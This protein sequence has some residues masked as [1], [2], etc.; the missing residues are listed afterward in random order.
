M[1]ATPNLWEGIGRQLRCPS[2]RAGQLTGHL[3]ALVNRHPNQLAI[4]ALGVSPADTVLELGFGPGRGVKALSALASRGR[5]LGIDQSPEMLALASRINR[6]AISEG[7]AELRLGHFDALPWA[8]E[9]VDKILAVN[10][11][12]FFGAAGVELREA[13]RV[14]RPGGEMAIYAT[15]RSTMA[16]WKFAGPETHRHVDETELRALAVRGGFGADDVSIVAV[17]LPLGIDGLLAVLRKGRAA[18]NPSTAVI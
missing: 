5:V 2:G 1:L 3:M 12:Y 4:E 7:R 11:V 10:V 9:A 8:G 14:L 17:K 16:G 15:A 18:R 13:R 6:R